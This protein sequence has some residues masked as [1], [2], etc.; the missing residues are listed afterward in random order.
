MKLAVITFFVFRF[1][2]CFAQ[3]KRLEFAIYFGNNFNNDSVT[4]I[5]NRVS[6][7]KNIKLKETM[8]SPQNLIIYAVVGV[9][10]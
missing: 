2:L 1:S 8:I 5:A 6:I 7:A 9:H 3:E 4:I 10:F